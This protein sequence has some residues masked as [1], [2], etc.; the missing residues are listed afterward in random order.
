MMKEDRWQKE[1]NKIDTDTWDNKK[2]IYN[3][4]K[5]IFIKNYNNISCCMRLLFG[6]LFIVRIWELFF[7]TEGCTINSFKMKAYFHKNM[8]IWMVLIWSDTWRKKWFDGYKCSSFSKVCH[9]AATGLVFEPYVC[10]CYPIHL[11]VVIWV[12]VYKMVDVS[13]GFSIDWNNWNNYMFEVCVDNRE[14]HY[15]QDIQE[16]MADK[17]LRHYKTMEVTGRSG[18]LWNGGKPRNW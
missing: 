7:S 17:W 12:D 6:I 5:A 8:S 14:E 9:I 1:L 15:T 4:N 16:V 2:I 18:I 11:L 13:E 3:T 10:K